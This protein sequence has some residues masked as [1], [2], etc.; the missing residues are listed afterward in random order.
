MGT[1]GLWSLRYPA[2]TDDVAQ[3]YLNIQQLAEDVDEAILADYGTRTS[4]LA[5]APLATGTAVT[6]T[7]PTLTSGELY[8]CEFTAYG[9][10]P[11]GAVLTTVDAKIRLDGTTI[12]QCRVLTQANT[13]SWCP[14]V[15]RAIAAPGSTGTAT[16]DCQITNVNSTTPNITVAGG[17]SYPMILTIRRIRT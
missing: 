4:D 15:V 3:G 16:L 12:G 2:N 17:T 1:T 9:V 10:A 5:L 7:T 13:G 8:L 6:F 11:Q 14:L